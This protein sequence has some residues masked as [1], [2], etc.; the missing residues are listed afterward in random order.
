MKCKY[1]GK[2][3]IWQSDFTFEEMRY[4]GEGVISVWYCPQCDKID[5]LKEVYKLWV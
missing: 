1:C 5:M 3:M 4:E 2:D